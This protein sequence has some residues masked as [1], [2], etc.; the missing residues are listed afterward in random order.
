MSAPVYEVAAKTTGERGSNKKFHRTSP[1]T[2]NNS[3]LMTPYRERF[4]PCTYNTETVYDLCGFLEVPKCIQF[5][6]S[7]LQDTNIKKT[8][9]CQLDDKTF[10]IR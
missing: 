6:V 5:H 1:E 2:H 4:L 3:A 8:D 9:I 10:V 7:A